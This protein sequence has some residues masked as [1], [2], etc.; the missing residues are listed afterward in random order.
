[1]ENLTTAHESEQ[2]NDLLTAIGTGVAPADINRIIT[3]LTT[4]T[5]AL[6]NISNKL[7]NVKIISGRATTDA[8]TGQVTVTFPTGTFQSTP[9]VTV[10]AVRAST[11][12]VGEAKV[13]SISN[14]GFTITY[15]R[16]TSSG[17]PSVASVAVEYIA[18]GN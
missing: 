3:A 16:V 9:H 12:D 11:N 2:W 14:N 4:M 8:T 17:T 5:I 18:V 1:M 13:S 15:T 10:S 7:S 6:N